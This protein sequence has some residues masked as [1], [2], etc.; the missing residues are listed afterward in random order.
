MPWTSSNHKKDEFMS[1]EKGSMI[2]VS[3]EA[4]FHDWSRYATLFV[5][6]GEE[7]IWFF[8][9]DMDPKLQVLS[10]QMTSI[11]K[12]YNEVIDIVKKIDGVRNV[13]QAKTLAKRPRVQVASVVLSKSSSRLANIVIHARFHRW[14]L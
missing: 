1:L 7:R 6:I 2:I 13:A 8:I 5:T 4:K 10:I 9:K 11:G 3:Y 12:S 14:L